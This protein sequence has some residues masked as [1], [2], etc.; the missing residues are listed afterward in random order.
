[1]PAK[2]G[3]WPRENVEIVRSL[4]E[5]AAARPRSRPRSSCSR[6]RRSLMSARRLSACIP[7][8]DSRS[9]PLGFGPA[10]PVALAVAVMVEHAH[11]G[12]SPGR[13]GQVCAGSRSAADA[14]APVAGAVSTEGTVAPPSSN[15]RSGRCIEEVDEA[16]QPER[17]HPEEEGV[18]LPPRQVRVARPGDVDRLED[19]PRGRDDVD[20]RPG[21]PAQHER[22]GHVAPAALAA[23]PERGD[24]RREEADVVGAGGER[25]EDAQDVRVGEGERDED[26][27]EQRRV[28]RR[29]VALGDL[30]PD[31][32]EREHAVA[33]VGE[34]DADGG[35]LDR[36]AAGDE[37]RHHHHEER[38]LR[39]GSE[40][41][42]DGRRHRVGLLARH[43]RAEVR[44]AEDERERGDEVDDPDADDRHDDRLGDLARGVARLLGDAA[45]GVEAEQHPA[46]DRDGAMKR[47]EVAAAAR[48]AAGVGERA[49]RL[50]AE[51]EDERDAD[52]DARDRLARD[53][54]V[55][56]V[57]QQLQ[58][59]DVHARRDRASSPAPGGSSRPCWGCRRR[60]AGRGTRRR[61]RRRSTASGSAPRCRSIRPT[62]RSAG[63]RAGAT[64]GRCRPRS[65]SAAASW[66]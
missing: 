37:R 9:T 6:S 23:Q 42:D 11:G 56:R 41:R 32:R 10:V 39:P 35:A 31:P 38:R 14:G 36:D 13:E 33:R 43:H 54:D 30:P 5:S 8:S 3:C 49:D 2:A 50:L 7:R 25:D 59:D 55:D 20:D 66:A 12:W 64:T 24:D 60:R 51:E 27:H 16:E 58:A 47:R 1:M 34:D 48:H 62:S 65:A 17:G 19:E 61:R 28:D 29:A 15:R 46:R 63:R 4:T 57:A 45:A 26:G 18:V 21:A 22:A 52:P 44:V 53:A 40:A